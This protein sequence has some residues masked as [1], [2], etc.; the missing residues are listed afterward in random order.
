MEI[1]NII[2]VIIQGMNGANLI[3]EEEVS[4]F[5]QKLLGYNR[6]VTEINKKRDTL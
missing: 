1:K 4:N 5:A 6:Y 3:T 2:I